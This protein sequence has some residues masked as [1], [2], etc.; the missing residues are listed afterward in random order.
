MLRDGRH[1][2]EQEN[3]T[4]ETEE[5]FDQKRRLYWTVRLLGKRSH[6]LDPSEVERVQLL[7]ELRW[8]ILMR[9]R[10]PRD[11]GT[12]LGR[13]CVGDLDGASNRGCLGQTK[14]KVQLVADRNRQVSAQLTSPFG[15]IEDV[16]RSKLGAATDLPGSFDGDSEQFTLL[17]HVLSDLSCFRQTT[18]PCPT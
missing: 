2:A 9:G 16:A 3:R 4:N 14:F 13:R 8:A 7:D 6:E 5:R 18:Y 1:R 17:D 10:N 15:E 11:A 12:E